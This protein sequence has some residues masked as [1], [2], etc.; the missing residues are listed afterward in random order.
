MII[1]KNG[2]T[3]KNEVSLRTNQE[4]D[5]QSDSEIFESK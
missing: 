3:F 4:A 5:Q 2:F 1:K